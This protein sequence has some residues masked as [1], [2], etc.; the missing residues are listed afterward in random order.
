MHEGWCSNGE[1]QLQHRKGACRGSWRWWYWRRQQQRHQWNQ[2]LQNSSRASATN[3]NHGV[4][5]QVGWWWVWR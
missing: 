2:L 3:D 1:G 4:C 5:W